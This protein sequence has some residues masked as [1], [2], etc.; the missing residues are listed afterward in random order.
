MVDLK[1]RILPK[2]AIVRFSGS[3]LYILAHVG[4]N[5]FN[6]IRLSDGH[7]KTNSWHHTSG[8]D[9]V[10]V[11]AQTWLYQ[12][13]PVVIHLPDFYKDYDDKIMSIINTDEVKQGEK[14]YNKKAIQCMRAL[15]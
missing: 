15:L 9:R 2:G 6:F 5:C 11:P 7:Q 12:G 3:G 13:P 4:M 1:K 14:N 8:H 10:I